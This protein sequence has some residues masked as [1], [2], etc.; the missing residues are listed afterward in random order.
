MIKNMKDK[1]D[2]LKKKYF[3][4]EKQ[5]LFLNSFFAFKAAAL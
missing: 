5:R 2:T 3:L 4:E 1:E